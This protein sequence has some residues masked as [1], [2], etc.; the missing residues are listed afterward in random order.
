M[1]QVFNGVTYYDTSE[2]CKVLQITRQTLNN[3]VQEKRIK[4]YKRGVSRTAYYL[5]SEVDNLNTLREE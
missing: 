5:K 1:T 3:M 2:A 4:R